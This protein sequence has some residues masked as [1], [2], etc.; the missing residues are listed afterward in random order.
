[1]NK[2]NFVVTVKESNG[3]KS[4]L[5]VEMHE[6]IGLDAGKIIVMELPEGSQ[7]DEAEKIANFLNNNLEN[8]SIKTLHK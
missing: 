3:D 1:M 5:E 7:F 4:W 8:F 2:R 6:D